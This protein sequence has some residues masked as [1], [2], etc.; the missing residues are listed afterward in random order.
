VNEELRSKQ[1]IRSSSSLAIE[2]NTST[3]RTKEIRRSNPS[4]VSEHSRED[5]SVEHEQQ[6]RGRLSISVTRSRRFSS[7]PG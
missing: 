5:A 7:T 3:V 2:Y 1:G 4:H 6:W